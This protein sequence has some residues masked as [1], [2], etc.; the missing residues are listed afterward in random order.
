MRLETLDT[1]M[2]R[3]QTKAEAVA[4]LMASFASHL[5]VA[6]TDTVRETSKPTDSQRLPQHQEAGPAPTSFFA[7]PQTDHSSV[8][9]LPKAATPVRPTDT[10]QHAAANHGATVDVAGPNDVRDRSADRRLT[11]SSIAPQ[12]QTTAQAPSAS[13]S[14]TEPSRGAKTEKSVSSAASTAQSGGNTAA[15]SGVADGHEVAPQNNAASTEAP[16]TPAKTG[17]EASTAPI[18]QK[19]PAEP[20][21]IQVADRAQASDVAP[22][23]AEHVA[24]AAKGM[25]SATQPD[26]ADEDT[27]EAP[28]TTASAP[29]Q[30]TDLAARAVMSEAAA[31]ANRTVATAP[32]APAEAPQIAPL[33]AAAPAAAALGIA[34]RP[35]AGAGQPAETDGAAE[36]KATPASTP[37]G[38]AEANHLDGADAVIRPQADG[39][40]LV[41]LAPSANGP[42]QMKLDVAGGMVSNPVFIAPYQQTR[43]NLEAL[44]PAIASATRG[45]AAMRIQSS[46]RN[47]ANASSQTQAD[48][49]AESG[50][51][52]HIDV[53]I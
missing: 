12:S 53:R 27:S 40:L 7:D 22:V 42:M 3:E 50:D 18:N 29:A 1:S 37:T 5:Q 16:A 14:P 24:V 17:A 51:H 47:P 31:A 35:R 41:T 10:E 6:T 13:A 8:S 39:G 32:A 4:R 19:A 23:V 21:P 30:T 36:A 49:S 28:V 44:R 9:A 43:N 20:A 34:P 26:G 45:G 46:S 33:T 15:A 48:L 52:P 38:K 2:R 11:A 25:K